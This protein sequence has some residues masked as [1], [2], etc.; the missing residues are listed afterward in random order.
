MGRLKMGICHGTNLVTAGMTAGMT[1]G[2][3]GKH[4]KNNLL[5]LNLTSIYDFPLFHLF[6]L[7]HL[8]PLLFSLLLVISFIRP[9]NEV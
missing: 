6:R 2:E 3:G 5:V 7:F 1:A 4:D 9:S 8:F